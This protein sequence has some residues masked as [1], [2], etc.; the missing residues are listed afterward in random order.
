VPRKPR[1]P[2]TKPDSDKPVPAGPQFNI[3]IG[4]GFPGG[5]HPGGGKPGGGMPKT[6]GGCGLRC[7]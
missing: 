7:G 6:G 1:K 2:V 5:G 3:Q 4:P